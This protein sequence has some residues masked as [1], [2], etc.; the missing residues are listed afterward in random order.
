VE[1]AR[2]GPDDRDPD[3]LAERLEP[4]VGEAADDD[5]VEAVP[6]RPPHR[7]AELRNDQGRL[8]GRLDRR[9]A[10]R[11]AP[12]LDL[13]AGRGALL[14][15]LAA[16]RDLLRAEDG[17]LHRARELVQNAHESPLRS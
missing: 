17:L 13:A 3:Q 11:E 7:L 1:G 10:V 16:P 12:D 15:E 6:L 14:Q 8:V 2:P 9:R 5:R 4:R